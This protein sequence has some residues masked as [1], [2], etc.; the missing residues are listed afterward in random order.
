[1]KTPK[2]RESEQ[3]LISRVVDYVVRVEPS[4]HDKR[5]AIESDLRAELGGGRWYVPAR[6][7]TERQAR[8][9]EVLSRFNG[10]NAREV[11]RQLNIHRGTVYKILKQ[12]G[13]S[14]DER[15]RIEQPG[16]ATGGGPGLESVA[17]L[18]SPAT[19]KGIR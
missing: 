11:A 18:P 15:G 14:H 16:S 1:M 2:R 13:I 7:A 8:V 5:S 4:L 6:P 3:D 19:R 17:A 12:P 9:R 10:R